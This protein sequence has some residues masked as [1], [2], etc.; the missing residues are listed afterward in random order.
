MT[1]QIDFRLTATIRKLAPE[2]RLAYGWASASGGNGQPLV[3]LQGDSI[4]EA[5]L[6]KAAHRFIADRRVARSMHKGE[7]IGEIVESA[8]LTS[9]VQQALGIDLGSVGWW[10]A[11]KLADE[12]T[13]LRVQSGELTGFSLG[14]RAVRRPLATDTPTA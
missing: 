8:V 11:V 5:E 10:I 4:A 12:A 13:W 14:G 7:P 1:S 2:G 3:D 9:A 6:V